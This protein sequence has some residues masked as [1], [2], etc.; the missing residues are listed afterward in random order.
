MVCH[1]LKNAAHLNGKIGD[2]RDYDDDTGRYEIHFEDKSLKPAA[3]KRGN[4]RIVF[5][6]PAAVEHEGALPT[7]AAT[8]AAA[9][10]DEARAEE[11]ATS[12]LAELDLEESESNTSNKQKG[13]KKKGKKNRKKK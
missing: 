7:A 5:E 13:K 9:H 12:L 2:A 4:L 3:V 6:L 8:A 10:T 11:A 1:G